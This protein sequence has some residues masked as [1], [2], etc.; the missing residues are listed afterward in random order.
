MI[1]HYKGFPVPMMSPKVFYDISIMF[2]T[3][4]IICHGHSIKMELVELKATY[5]DGCK[6]PIS[7]CHSTLWWIDVFLYVFVWMGGYFDFGYGVHFLGFVSFTLMVCCFQLF[8]V[9]CC[10]LF[11]AFVFLLMN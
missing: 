5:F 2:H 8:K 9:Y 11:F 10:F 3:N 1:Y 7:P 6:R 4:A